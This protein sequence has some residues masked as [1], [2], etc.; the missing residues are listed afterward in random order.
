MRSTFYTCSKCVGKNSRLI[1]FGK[2]KNGKQR[3]QCILCR[4]TS[5]LNYSY[6]AYRRNTNTKIIRLTKEG[7]GIRGISRFLRISTTTL[8]KR[9]INISDRIQPPSINYKKIYE[10][11]EL[12]TYI[13]NKKQIVWLV[14]ALERDSKNVLCF[15]LGKRSNDTLN[16]VIKSLLH[17]NP[18]KIYTD[19]L[20]NY[21]Y[22]IPKGIHHTKRFGTN[23]I[24]RK[25]LSLRTHLKRLNR[26]TICFSK[27]VLMLSSVLKIYFWS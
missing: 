5:V 16:V 25:N 12:R 15:N 14:Y 24:E 23:S 2:T 10:V 18:E 8:L 22:L 4:K 9:I 27:S 13:G 20:R 26:K 21:Q 7:M 11:D 19:K 3:F 6:Q 17:S 1:K